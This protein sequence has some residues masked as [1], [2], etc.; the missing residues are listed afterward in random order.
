MARGDEGS[1]RV[2]FPGESPETMDDLR[3]ECS[4]LRQRVSGLEAENAELAAQVREWRRWYAQSY[5]PQMEFLDLEVA[6]L[7]SLAPPMSKTLGAARASGAASGSG[8]GGSWRAP[9]AVAPP[10]LRRCTSEA[11]GRAGTRMLRRPVA[12]GAELPPLAGGGAGR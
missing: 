9:S 3:Q 5:R 10:G 7:C 4:T 11:G 8:S 6:R 2:P 1:P 12:G